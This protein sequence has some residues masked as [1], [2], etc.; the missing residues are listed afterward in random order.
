M[1][2]FYVLKNNTSPFRQFLSEFKISYARSYSIIVVC[3][4]ILCRRH[5]SPDAVA[6][7]K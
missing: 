5:R 2:S 7:F 4:I 3:H 6:L 1:K